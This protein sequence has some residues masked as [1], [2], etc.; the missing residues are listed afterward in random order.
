M[1]WYHADITFSDFKE[2][3]EETAQSDCVKMVEM[4]RAYWMEQA[5]KVP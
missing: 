1:T 4:I 2:H 3:L 5:K